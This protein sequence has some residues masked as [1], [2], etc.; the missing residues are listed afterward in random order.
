VQELLLCAFQGKLVTKLLQLAAATTTI[1]KDREGH[2]I[3][4]PKGISAE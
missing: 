4:I 3:I 1:I 2:I